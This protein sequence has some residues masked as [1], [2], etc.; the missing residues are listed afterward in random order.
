MNI[1]SYCSY[2]ATCQH[3]YSTHYNTITVDL[4]NEKPR[5]VFRFIAA[6]ENSVVIALDELCKVIVILESISLAICNYSD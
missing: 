1:I 6:L 2:V 4:T 5:I 3:C